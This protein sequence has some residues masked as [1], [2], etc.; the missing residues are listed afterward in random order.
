MPALSSNAPLTMH[1]ERA[2]T[3]KDRP[4]NVLEHRVRAVADATTHRVP[5]T[6]YG[7]HQKRYRAPLTSHIHFGTAAQ[8]AA[9]N[10]ILDRV[11][12]P[13]ELV[14]VQRQWSAV[15]TGALYA[16][17][18]RQLKALRSDMAA[19]LVLVDAALGAVGK[20]ISAMKEQENGKQKAHPTNAGAAAPDKGAQKKGKTGQ[21]ARRGGNAPAP[22]RQVRD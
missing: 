4:Q 21:K 1:A 14:A 20:Q 3:A 13:P 10:D 16:K 5:P 12:L 6:V 7:P 11:K 18:A 15:Y 19:M 2:L 8:I 17:N 22:R 9:R